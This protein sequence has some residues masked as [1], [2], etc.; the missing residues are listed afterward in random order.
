MAARYV[1]RGRSSDANLL[2]AEIMLVCSIV[3][4]HWGWDAA[5]IICIGLTVLFVV[6]SRLKEEDR[7]FVCALVGIAWGSG[8]FFLLLTAHASIITCAVFVPFVGAIG[9]AAHH[10]ALQFMRADEAEI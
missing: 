7:T 10:M 9:F 5:L 2:F 8:A 6:I 4:Y 1:R 3:W